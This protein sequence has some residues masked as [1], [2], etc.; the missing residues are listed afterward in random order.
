[1]KDTNESLTSSTPNEQIEEKIKDIVAGVSPPESD[2]I[3]KNVE[4][5]C[6]LFENTDEK[7]K[8]IVVGILTILYLKGKLHK[9]GLELN[10]MRER[11]GI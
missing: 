9:T 2:A 6:A 10:E 7:K 4:A 11:Y 5:I 3:F 8:Y 1:M